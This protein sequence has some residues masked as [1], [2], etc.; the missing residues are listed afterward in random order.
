VIPAQDLPPIA[1][2]VC[3]VCYRLR[4]DDAGAC[5]REREDLARFERQQRELADGRALDREVSL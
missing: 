3:D 4:C 5:D 1:R 2:P